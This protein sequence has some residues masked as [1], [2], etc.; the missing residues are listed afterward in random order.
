MKLS[1]L[2]SNKPQIFEP[3]SFISNL[4]VVLAE[5]RLP[6]NKQKNTHNLGK[7]ILGRLIDFCFLSTPKESFFLKKH[8]EFFKEFIFFME[9]ELF[10][11]TFATV[12]RSVIEPTKISFKKH[13]YGKQDFTM[14]SESS[15]DHLNIPM[16]KAKK[17]LDGLLDLSSMKEWSY[18]YG[19]DYLLRS[20]ED[21][22]DVFQL[23]K[24]VYKQSS[25]K[26]YLAH[27]LGFN[28]KLIQEHYNKE[29][30][31]SDKRK[32]EEIIKKELADSDDNLS[33]V[34]G[35][36]FLKQKDV[37]KKQKLLDTFDFR[38]QDKEKTK[39]LVDEINE[40]IA[41]LNTE[42]YYL[43]QNK[44]KIDA[45]LNE[46]QILFNPDEA[47][48]LFEEV[49]L[50]FPDQIKRDFVQLIEF[51][52]AIT[53]ERKGYLIEERKEIDNR[54]KDIN[55]E[56][57]NL[58]KRSSE[59]LLFLGESEAFNKYKQLSNDLVILK[60]DMASLEHHRKELLRLQEL[61]KE[62][63]I[64]ENEKQQLQTL[65]EE[66]IEKQ[67]SD[68][69][70]LFYFIR[71]YFN[72]IIEEIID[73]EALLTVKTNKEGHIEF[74]AD[75]LDDIDN[76]TSADK[77]HTYKKLLCIAFDMAVLFAHSQIKFLRFVFHDGVFESFDDR[78][79]EKLLYEIRRY[80]DFGIQHI[81]TLN[82]SDLP[83][84]F[85]PDESMFDDSE[86]ILKLHD[87]D[88]RGRLFKMPT[89]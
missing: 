83:A 86:I 50:F 33:E 85:L 17:Y 25:W 37:E 14:L 71:R 5:I 41:S 63:R 54:L 30:H 23:R 39:Q 2:Y 70:S 78:I 36:L 74:K 61:R 38:E 77:G 40:S 53:Q 79:K 43:M 84:H 11:N 73:R 82:D 42:R 15:W 19:L 20:Q 44:K 9:I 64:L 62:I 48:Q 57:N 59:I 4:N 3:I 76:T 34:E 46:T 67:N 72:E 31:L 87:E 35:K 68:K 66:D 51:N 60:T 52:R 27:V 22:N 49:G 10:D 69:N 75:I 80:S 58:G 56:L 7:T 26:P 1:A 29:A 16:D 88:E 55:N 47:Q 28:D 81:I 65:I 21:Y 18:R 45:S 13:L 8:R 89:W 6:E 32:S 24:Y 12:R